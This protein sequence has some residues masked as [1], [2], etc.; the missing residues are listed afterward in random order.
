MPGSTR[1]VSA[2]SADLDGAAES[3]ALAFADDPWT[4][5]VVPTAERRARL[6]ELQGIC[7]ARAHAYGRVLVASAGAIA[8]LPTDAPPIH[9][10]VV[11]RLVDLHGDRIERLR[12]VDLPEP[13]RGAW[14]V[15]TLGVRPSHRGKG[16][17]NALLV[18]ALVEIQD[19][20][21]PLA[22]DT[23]NPRSVRLY[24]RYGFRVVEQTQI[25]DGP[26]L[27]SLLRDA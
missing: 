2:T 27:W 4:E 24:G 6:V 14:Q 20:R 21:V 16:V 17:G 11:D 1:V 22:V 13:V 3:L 15:E 19:L 8:V 9:A 26:T 25:P 5:W 18:A 7:L 23:S 10:R 12:R